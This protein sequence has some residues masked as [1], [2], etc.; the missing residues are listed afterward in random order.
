ME[1]ASPGSNRKNESNG[2]QKG[3]DLK[4]EVISIVE[5]PK[6][7]GL[8]NLRALTFLLLWYFFSGCTLFLN[9]H[10]LTS[11]NGNPTVLGKTFEVK[12]K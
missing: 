5:A 12:Q 7:K 6:K 8:L 11:L 1:K 4:R 2:L 3:K 10:I 9:K